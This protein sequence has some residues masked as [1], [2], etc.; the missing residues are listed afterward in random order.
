MKTISEKEQTN[1]SK[2]ST[3]KEAALMKLPK[4]VRTALIY[5]GK[6]S[7]KSPQ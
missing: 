7:K 3:L 4:D 6:S 5:M 2:I 1:P